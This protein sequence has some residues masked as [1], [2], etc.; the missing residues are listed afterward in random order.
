MFMLLRAYSINNRKDVLTFIDSN[1]NLVETQKPRDII[2]S[3]DSDWNCWCVGINSGSRRSIAKSNYYWPII[4][5]Q[6][7]VYHGHWYHCNSKNSKNNSSLI[8]FEV[9][10]F[11]EMLGLDS[12]SLC[13]VI[14][15]AN[16]HAECK[17]TAE[18]SE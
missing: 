3:H 6:T 16:W 12:V 8:G 1:I 14:M 18:Y 13:L 17:D 5:R 11:R 7:T 9:E 2:V 15:R 10:K 4:R